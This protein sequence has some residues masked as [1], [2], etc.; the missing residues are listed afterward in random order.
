MFNSATDTS[1]HRRRRFGMTEVLL[2][3]GILA[4]S[5]FTLVNDGRQ[6]L[7]TLLSGFEDAIGG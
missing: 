6:T 4:F 7:G 2:I 5:A 3:A 1:D